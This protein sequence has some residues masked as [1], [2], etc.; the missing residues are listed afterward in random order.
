MR[1]FSPFLFII[2]HTEGSLVSITGA[3]SSSPDGAY[4]CIMMGKRQIRA[5][6][7][8]FIFKGL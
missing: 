3:I 2:T 1:F 8:G 6:F 4:V 7:K 5:E